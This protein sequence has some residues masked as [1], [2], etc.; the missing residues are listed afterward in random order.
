MQSV[1]E[2]SHVFSISRGSF[3]PAKETFGH[4]PS[5]NGKFCQNAKITGRRGRLT[6]W[7]CRGCECVCWLLLRWSRLAAGLSFSLAKLAGQQAGMRTWCSL[8]PLFMHRSCC[9]QEALQPFHKIWNLKRPPSAPRGQ[10]RHSRKRFARPS[11][12]WNGVPL[13]NLYCMV[14]GFEPGD[15]QRSLCLCVVLVVQ[16]RPFGVACPVCPVPAGDQT[17]GC[18]LCIQEHTLPMRSCLQ[19]ALL[20]PFIQHCLD[21]A[22]GAGPTLVKSDACQVGGRLAAHASCACIWAF[23]SGL[24]NATAHYKWS[25]VAFGSTDASAGCWHKSIRLPP[26]LI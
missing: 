9:P 8:V 11:Q 23:A 12:S 7:D 13:Q 1:C 5:Q 6:V 24:S 17:L 15:V 3:G 18:T 10:A 22:Q 21:S 14:F 26:A 2:R 19:L 4:W 20:N 16:D 25:E